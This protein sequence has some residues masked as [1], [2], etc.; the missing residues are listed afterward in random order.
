M[1]LFLLSLIIIS[2]TSCYKD[3]NITGQ[4]SDEH[5]LRHKGVDMPV[6]VRGNIESEEFIIFIHGGPKLSSIEEAVTNQFEKLHEK[7]AVVYYD[8]RSGGFTHGSRTDNLSLD[9]MV[10][11]M[12][13]VIDFIQS[14]Y[15]KANN[16]FLMGHSWGGFLG[17]AYLVEPSRQ[18]KVNGWINL[19][20]VHNFSLLWLEERKFVLQYAQEQIDADNDSDFWQDAIDEVTPL[21]TIEGPEQYFVINYFA[22]IIDGTLDDKSVIDDISLVEFMSSPVGTGVNQIRIENLDAVSTDGNFTT[23]MPNITIP[24][25]LIY[26][27]LDA[28]VPKAMGEDTQSL[29]GTPEEDV[30]L[31]TLEN[32]GHDIWK[33]E[34][35]RFIAEV[36]TF[37]EAYK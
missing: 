16:I 21:T 4:Y 29:L 19:A 33:A 22:Q 9:Q 11:D 36:T 34:Y 7:Y 35:D 5:Y 32:S 20:G 13:V 37:V 1:R 31:V 27:S 24:S 28:I 23:L 10:E 8:Q 6:W 3:P 18:A 15:E 25:L 12:D 30:Y 26:G 14:K 17:T 2:L